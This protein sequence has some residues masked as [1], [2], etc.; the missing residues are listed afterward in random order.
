MGLDVGD[1][2]AGEDGVGGVRVGPDLDDRSRA[3]VLAPV[4]LDAVALGDVGARQ[5][6]RPLFERPVPAGAHVDQVQVA[7]RDAIR[8]ERQREE[9]RRRAGPPGGTVGKLGRRPEDP[10][11]ATVR[12]TQ[13]RAGNRVGTVGGDRQDDRFLVARVEAARRA[14]A[15]NVLARPDRRVV[16][17]RGPG[18]LGALAHH[19]ER[20]IADG[21][22]RI[23]AMTTM[24][25]RTM[26]TIRLIVADRATR[27]RTQ[28]TAP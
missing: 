2:H 5:R 15:G 14:P 19:A 27:P 9:V 23:T 20:G 7:P 17:L 6:L 8:R 24:R 22:T 26:R 18:G 12:V 25:A 16:P 10:D 1:D 13:G 3:E 11:D 21:A 28:W 4:D